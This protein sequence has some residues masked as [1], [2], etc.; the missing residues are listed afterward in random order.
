MTR[1]RIVLAGCGALLVS[2]AATA[3][4]PALGELYVVTELGEL[5]R[6]DP[7]TGDSTHVAAVPLK[8][9]GRIALDDDRGAFVRDGAGAVHRVVLD[10]GVVTPLAAGDFLNGTFARGIAA[11]GVDAIATSRIEVGGVERAAIVRVDPLGDQDL[12]ADVPPDPIGV[13]VEADGSILVLYRSRVL[14]VDPATGDSEPLASEDLLDSALDLDVLPDDTIAVLQSDLSAAIVLIDPVSGVQSLAAAATGVEGPVD[15]DRVTG[16]SS[17]GIGGFHITTGRGNLPIENFP[18]AVVDF[19][20]G[21]ATRA[22]TG[23][24]ALEAPSDVAAPEPGAALLLAAGASL[25]LFL[26]LALARRSQERCG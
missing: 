17:D 3:G 24:S 11:D 9:G 7:Q 5:E 14:R 13:A 16:F 19:T 12:V 25:L 8:L 2:H 1:L 4:V 22:V 15:F 26:R 20:P 23:H 18:G 21:G 10:T 6:I